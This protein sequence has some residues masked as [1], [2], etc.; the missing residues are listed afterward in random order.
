[1]NADSKSEDARRKLGFGLVFSLKKDGIARG[2]AVFVSLANEKENEIILKDKV[3]AMYSFNKGTS[4]QDYPSS[5]MGSI[6]LLRQ[7]YFDADWYRKQAPERVVGGEVNISL[8]A[9]NKLQSLPQIFEAGDKLSVLRADK[10]GDEFKMQYIIKGSGDEYQRMD[11]IK[12]T[13]ARF[14]LP[15]NFPATFDVE[16]P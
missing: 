7:T 5:L 11:D 6:A 16:D 13:N 12:A 8:D 15:L 3:A 9:W 10:V 4:T 1:M 2:S 14:I